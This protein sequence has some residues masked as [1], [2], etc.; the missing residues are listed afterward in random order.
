MFA[1]GLM[2]L[3]PAKIKIFSFVPD[4]QILINEISAYGRQITHILLQFFLK[5]LVTVH[6]KTEIT[7]SLKRKVTSNFSGK[8]TFPTT[9]VKVRM[10]AGLRVHPREDI[11]K[12]E[13]TH[14]HIHTGFSFQ[15]PHPTQPSYKYLSIS[16]E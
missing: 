4:C 1:V 7:T 15:A 16:P 5:T 10:F 3:T 9:H 6:L 11:G 2:G 12:Y 8:A 13:K 14:K